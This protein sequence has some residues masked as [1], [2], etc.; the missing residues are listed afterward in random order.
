M[1]GAVVVL[2]VL[3]AALAVGCL[4]LLIRW[5]DGTREN[6]KLRAKAWE[7]E[8]SI[9]RLLD[10]QQLT[11]MSLAEKQKELNDVLEHWS[12]VGSPCDTAPK[13]LPGARPG[14][15]APGSTGGSRADDLTPVDTIIPGVP[16]GRKPDLPR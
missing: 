14:G 15:G 2:T 12:D 11:K 1:T 8:W 4:V 16:V 10:G 9:K 7:L 13:L 3:C 6:E 5:M